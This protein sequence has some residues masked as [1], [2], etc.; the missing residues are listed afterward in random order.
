H[1]NAGNLASWFADTS[2]YRQA[3]FDLFML[4]Y[5]GYGKSTGRI[6]SE[7]QLRSDAAIAWHQIAPLYQGRRKVILGR[8]L[9]SALAARLAADTHPD[10]TILISPYWS[11]TELARTHFPMV[12]TV[13]LRYRLETF[14]DVARMDGPL[15]LV[16]GGRDAVIPF[17]H[18]VRLQELA[19]SAQLVGISSAAH[20]DIEDFG[21]ARRAI[22]ERLAKL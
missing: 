5:R 6:R 10:L 12:P 16:H 11:M 9:G 18:S 13:L 2:L 20:N 3:N 22:A 8:S 7:E 21:E 14:R 19:H 17:E 15:L 4:D 1:G